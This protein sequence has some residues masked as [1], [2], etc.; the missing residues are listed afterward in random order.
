[1]LYWIGDIIE[2]YDTDKPIKWYNFFKK[3]KIHYLCSYW[4]GGNIK[5]QHELNPGELFI[6]IHYY[7]GL[8]ILQPLNLIIPKD[9]Y[10]TSSYKNFRVISKSEYTKMTRKEKLK[11][12]Q[13]V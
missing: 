3:K 4:N 10:C 11:K 8:L 6:V 13:D 5:Y 7:L 12:L 9:D 2:F 1:M